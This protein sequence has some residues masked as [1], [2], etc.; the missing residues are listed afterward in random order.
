M[1]VAHHFR[2]HIAECDLAH[3]SSVADVAAWDE[4]VTGEVREFLGPAIEI[5]F[6]NCLDR[7]RDFAFDHPYGAKI[8]VVFDQGIENPRLHTIIDMYKKYGRDR[9]E[10]VSITFGKVKEIYPLQA[11]DIIATQSYWMA[12]EWMNI[13]MTKDAD[14][15]F[16]HS[17]KGRRGEG[18]IFDRE[19]IINELRRRGPD[20]KLLPVPNPLMNIGTR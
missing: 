13:R 5:C 8:A 3:T 18:L 19:A 17:F 11:A 14:V 9:P 6:V 15:Y 10:F 16:R 20:V 4:L 2:R 7:A 12:Q 1:L